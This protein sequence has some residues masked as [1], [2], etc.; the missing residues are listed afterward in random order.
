[1]EVTLGELLLSRYFWAY[2]S[3]IAFWRDLRDEKER[4]MFCQEMIGENGRAGLLFLNNIMNI[5]FDCLRLSKQASFS[6]QYA[7]VGFW[8]KV[9]PIQ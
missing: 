9:F 2:I 4:Q 1:M 5:Y 8:S 7:L 3:D 6:A